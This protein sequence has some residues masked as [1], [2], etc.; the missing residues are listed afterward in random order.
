M[1]TAK[2]YRA[3]PDKRVLV[4]N[5]SLVSA[6][7]VKS[8]SLTPNKDIWFHL[9]GCN[10]FSKVFSHQTYITIPCF[11]KKEGLRET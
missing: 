9:L 5:W 10:G 4:K 3:L 11:W 8:A 2:H 1:P 7:A 6:I